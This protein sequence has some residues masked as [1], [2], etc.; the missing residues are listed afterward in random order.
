MSAYAANGVFTRD[1]AVYYPKGKNGV[2]GRLCIEFCNIV[3]GW[4]PLCLLILRANIVESL[5]RF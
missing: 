4:M 3:K 5:I 2:F 1:I